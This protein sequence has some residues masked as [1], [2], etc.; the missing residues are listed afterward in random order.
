MSNLVRITLTRAN[1]FE[2]QTAKMPVS[3]MQ[4]IFVHGANT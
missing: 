4:V 3:G 2:K 1:P